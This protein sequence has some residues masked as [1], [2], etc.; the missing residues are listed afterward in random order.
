MQE[1]QVYFQG[2]PIGCRKRR[3]FLTTDQ[4]DPGNVGGS[5]CA[6]AAQGCA[7]AA[8]GCEFAAQ[9]CEFAAQ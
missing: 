4:S 1:A 2:G 5:G 3:Y 6:F 8:Q 7:F 9:G